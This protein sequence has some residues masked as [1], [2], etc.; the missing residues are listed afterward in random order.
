MLTNDFFKLDFSRQEPPQGAK[1]STGTHVFFVI[2]FWFKPL[3]K[4]V[5]RE[6]APLKSTRT[7]CRKSV[8]EMHIKTCS[9]ICLQQF[10]YKYI[11]S[12][13]ANK[14]VLANRGHSRI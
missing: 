4:I 9:F 10:A 3:L 14:T 6:T 1:D 2:F 13:S 8:I 7:Y 11:Y 5:G 12:P